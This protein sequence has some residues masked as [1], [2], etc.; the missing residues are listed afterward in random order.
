[1]IER[2]NLRRIFFHNRDKYLLLMLSLVLLLFLVGCSAS[3]EATGNNSG[4]S[5]DSIRL[6][7][8][9][10]PTPIS[11]PGTGDDLGTWQPCDDAP[12]SQLEVGNLAVTQEI[13]LKMRL[14][15]EPGLQGNLGGEI[16]PSDVLEVINGPACYDQMVW[17]EVRSMANGQTGWVAEGNFY[18][19]WLVRV[20]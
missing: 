20:D 3:G 5:G 6:P 7:P 15:K 18:N 11:I 9:W 13:S 1:M 17:W 12:P 10:T 8:A 4:G 19:N 14:R 16:D 2:K